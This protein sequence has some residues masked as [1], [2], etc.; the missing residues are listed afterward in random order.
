METFT[1]CM[2]HFV[3]VEI[4]LLHSDFV[5]CIEKFHKSSMLQ[6]SFHAYKIYMHHAETCKKCQVTYKTCYTSMQAQLGKSRN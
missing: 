5:C 3:K 2:E 6:S 4:C 1:Y